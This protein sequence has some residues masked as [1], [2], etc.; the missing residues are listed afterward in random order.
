MMDF[1]VVYAPDVSLPQLMTQAKESLPEALPFDQMMPKFRHLLL[2]L[3]HQWQPSHPSR[4]RLKAYSN[5]FLGESPAVSQPF[6]MIFED[7]A[8]FVEDFKVAK[9]NFEYQEGESCLYLKDFLLLVEVF[10]MIAV[11][12]RTH[13]ESVGGCCE[14]EKCKTVEELF[15]KILTESLSQ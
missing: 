5:V 15:C 12:N 4:V 9:P 11:K 7:I 8:A 10:Y 6:N 13:L 2:K 1:G 3:S 14:K